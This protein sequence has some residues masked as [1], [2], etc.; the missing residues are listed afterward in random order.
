MIN[1]KVPTP[2]R[3]VTAV[4]VER[5][6]VLMMTK[7]PSAALPIT[8]GLPKGSL[9]KHKRQ[10]GAVEKARSPPTTVLIVTN[11]KLLPFSA[12]VNTASLVIFPFLLNCDILARQ[13]KAA[14]T[15]KGSKQTT[16]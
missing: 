12:M 6:L 8:I 5:P 9:R 11:R 10:D 4:K 16:L 1:E 13:H 15:Q 3:W 2:L 14:S 7:G